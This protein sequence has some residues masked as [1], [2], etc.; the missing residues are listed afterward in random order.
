MALNVDVPAT[1]NGDG[2]VTKSTAAAPGFALPVL[3]S[4]RVTD[5][6]DISTPPIADW[7]SDLGASPVTINQ[8]SGRCQIAAGQSAV[9]VNN[10]LLGP[11]DTVLVQPMDLDATATRWKVEVSVMGN[12]FTITANA[13]ATAA[14]RFSWVVV[15]K[16]TP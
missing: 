11:D 8:P 3:T 1:P 10:S 9:Q 14:T 4:G 16:Q 13:A 7:V 5:Q 2:Q 6:L 12:S 15:K